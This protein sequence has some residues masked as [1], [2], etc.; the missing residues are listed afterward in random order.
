MLPDRFG[1]RTEDYSLL[2]Q[3]LTEGR[4]DR[5]R[6]KDSIYGNNSGKNL[7]LV[8]RN[9]ELLECFGQ[10]GIDFLRPVLVLFGSRI[11][12]NVLK[13]NFGHIQMGP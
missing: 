11:L 1:E 2:R 12:D 3:S 13:I 5:D 10:G 7:P 8:K 9:P 6:I 4:R